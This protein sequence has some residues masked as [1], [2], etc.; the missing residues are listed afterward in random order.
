[1]GSPICDLNSS[2]N[3]SERLR[4]LRVVAETRGR[5]LRGIRQ[6]FHDRQF[7][8]VET[9][10]R[11]Q[12]PAPEVHI[13]AE[14]SGG[15]YLRPSPELHMKRL[16]AAGY[17]R[18]FQMG[19]CFRRGERGHLHNPEY[20]MLEW[21]RSHADSSDI[22]VDTKALVTSLA[23]EILGATD[24]MYRGCAVQ[25]LPFWERITVADAFRQ[26]AGWDPTQSFDADRFDLDMVDKVEPNLPR[27]VPVILAD[28]P[29]EAASLARQKD[30]H[31]PVA[32][33]WELY[34]GGVELANAYTELN[35]PR[36]QRLRFE[37]WRVQRKARGQDDYP[38]DEDFL[39]A[40]EA[41]MPPSGGIALGVDRLVMLLTDS[42]TLDDVILFRD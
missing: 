11:I 26:Y 21:Y 32:D 7:L 13:A 19:P 4:G 3:D 36:E 6:F 33:R 18:V 9:P 38:L 40:L 34:I 2:T 31:P 17:S 25:L 29:V 20:C 39:A 1:M 10:V 27:N 35:D 14:S 15:R 8:E 23:R 42:A 30:T 41:G 16:L 5:I 22:L 12:A 24:L 28:Y 37:T